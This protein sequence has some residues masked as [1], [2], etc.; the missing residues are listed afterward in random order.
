MDHRNELS[1]SENIPGYLVKVIE[2]SLK[3]DLGMHN[4]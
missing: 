4:R 3:Y 1:I 2:I